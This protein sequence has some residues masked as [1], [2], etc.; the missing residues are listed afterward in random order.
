MQH[1]P[2]FTGKTMKIVPPRSRVLSLLCAG[3]LLAGVLSPA[4]LARAHEV[5]ASSAANSRWHSPAKQLTVTFLGKDK[6]ENAVLVLKNAAVLDTEV[7]IQSD[8]SAITLVSG[9]SI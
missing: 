4:Q 3:C 5:F 9:D 7:L 8:A 1:A 6:K 2:F